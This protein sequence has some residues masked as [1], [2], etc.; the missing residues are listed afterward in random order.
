MEGELD[1]DTLHIHDKID[2]NYTKNVQ[3]MDEL[4]RYTVTNIESN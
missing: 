3:K 4:E 2:T 1:N